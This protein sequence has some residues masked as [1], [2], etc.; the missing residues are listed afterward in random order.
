[1]KIMLQK[2]FTLVELLITIAIIGIL[3]ATVIR[4]LS[5]ARD[6]GIVAKIKLEMAGITSRAITENT[7]YFSYDTVC[8]SNGATQS[9]EII[10]I[11]D[12]IN[13]M[14]SSSVVCNSDVAAYAASVPVGSVHWCVDSL[15]EKKEIPDPLETSPAELAC[16]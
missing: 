7:L 12:S 5:T 14:A 13:A 11:I 1:M 16:P 15:G 9:P 6:E 4:S 3:A 2:G 8:G 10:A